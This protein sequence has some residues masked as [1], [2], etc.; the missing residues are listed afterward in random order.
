MSGEKLKLLWGTAADFEIEKEEAHFKLG[1]CTVD[2]YEVIKLDR[3]Q[4]HSLMLY[5]QEHLGYS[6]VDKLKDHLKGYW[7]C[8]CGLT[9]PKDFICERIKS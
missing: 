3:N 6:S 8:G 9:H 7:L 5:L 1:I 2:G 4:A